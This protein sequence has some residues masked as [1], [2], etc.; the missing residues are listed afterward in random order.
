MS[1]F[2]KKNPLQINRLNVFYSSVEVHVEAF[3]KMHGMS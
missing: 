2:N 3:F 1:S